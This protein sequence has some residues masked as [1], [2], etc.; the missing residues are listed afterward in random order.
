M[1]FSKTTTAVALLASAG[2]LI[3]GC[4][5]NETGSSTHTQE[6]KLSGELIGAGA[7]S[8][9][10]AQE[11]WIAA[12]Q[13]KHPQVTVNYDPS[14]SGSGR[15]TF[16]AGASVFAGSDRAFKTSE[17]ASGNFASCKAGSGIVELPA[18]ISPI[19]LVFNLEGVNTL[20]LAPETIARI[21]TGKITQWNDP[22][23]VEQNPQAQLPALAITAVHRSD[24]SGTTQNFTDYLTSTAKEVWTAGKVE[25]WPSE[26][27]GEA[28]AQTSGMVAAV[29]NGKGTIGYA[30]ASR[31]AGLG[32]VHVKV[33]DS[34][35]G[36]TAE[37]AARIIEKSPLEKE[38]SK[39]DLAISIDRSSSEAN[40]YPIVLVSYLIG[41]Q[42]YA[43][44][45]QG[46]LAKEYLRYVISEEGQGQAAKIAGS[47]P[48]SATLRERMLG[49]IDSIH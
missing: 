7:S 16:Q 31:A 33:G 36:P 47:A 3:S 9:G 40:V 24:K 15:E 5:A 45:A 39:G 34:Y 14:G 10:S 21:F 29:Q 41:C 18:Y 4:A 17:I 13:Q 8:Q 25:T 48:I 28:A 49:I 27:G 43:D 44:S 26:Y 23:I 32:L 1:K 20:N 46:T 11:G 22:E 35:T 12:F 6:S 37:A 19:A 30:D 42:E 2:L 38:R